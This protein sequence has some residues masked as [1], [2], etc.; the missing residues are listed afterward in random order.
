MQAMPR[1]VRTQFCEQVTATAET[2]RKV[3]Q[4][5][6]AVGFLLAAIAAVGCGRQVTPNPPGAA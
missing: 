2:F 6:A 5:V 3:F 1:F 4:N